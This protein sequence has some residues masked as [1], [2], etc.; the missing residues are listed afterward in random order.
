MGTIPEDL[1][2][3]ADMMFAETGMPSHVLAADREC[4]S[5]E[6][7]VCFRAWLP[8]KESE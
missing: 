1:A 7:R 3:R 4:A 8:S 6:P 5:Y 2:A